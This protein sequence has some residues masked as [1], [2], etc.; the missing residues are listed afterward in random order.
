MSK[1]NIARSF[2]VNNKKPMPH[3]VNVWLKYIKMIEQLKSGKILT[4]I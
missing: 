3:T 4:Q 1:E 2:T